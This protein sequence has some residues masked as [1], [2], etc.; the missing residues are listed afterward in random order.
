M[1]WSSLGLF[2]TKTKDFPLFVPVEREA[3]LEGMQREG[4]G[5]LALCNSV[6]DVGGQEGQADD[7]GNVTPAQFFL[8]LNYF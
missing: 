7:S 4:R 5:K 3:F 2:S 8:V 6:H 1:C